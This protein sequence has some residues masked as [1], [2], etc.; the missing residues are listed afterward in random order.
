MFKNRLEIP[1]IIRE[2]EAMKEKKNK[3]EI[4]K[5]KNITEIKNSIDGWNNI[6]RH[7]RKQVSELKER[8]VVVNVEA[9][10]GKNRKWKIN[11]R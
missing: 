1:N 2:L 5:I 3:T 6:I 8:L 9:Q 4:L 11:V 7:S 10:R